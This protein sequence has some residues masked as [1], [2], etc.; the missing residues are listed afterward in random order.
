MF[1]SASTKLLYT[2]SPKPFTADFSCEFLPIAS[3]QR[4]S[5]IFLYCSTSSP[6][7]QRS[8]TPNIQQARAPMSR[9]HLPPLQTRLCYPRRTKASNY[10]SSSSGVGSD[11]PRPRCR[12]KAGAHRG[13]LVLNVRSS[14]GQSISNTELEESKST[15]LKVVCRSAYL[16]A[17]HSSAVA[18]HVE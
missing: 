5:A 11:S 16:T 14:N 13:E 12:I 9:S 2:T 15:A 10:S 3:W 4:C 8:S 1:R 7:V 6:S 17:H 18:R